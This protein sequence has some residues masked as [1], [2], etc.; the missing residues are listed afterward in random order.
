MGVLILNIDPNFLF[1]IVL[2]WQDQRFMKSNMTIAQTKMCY[3]GIVRKEQVDELWKPGIYIDGTVDGVS[4]ATLI[5][6]PLT[7]LFTSG[8]STLVYK[9]S[10][11]SSPSSPSSSSSGH[12]TIEHW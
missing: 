2:I 12:K 6:S 10:F 3:P 5:I 4:R 8:D 11:S 1:R 9:C 7:A